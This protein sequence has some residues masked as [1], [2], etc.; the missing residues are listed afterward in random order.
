MA[1]IAD[2]IE[3]FHSGMFRGH[4]FGYTIVCKIIQAGY[5][6]PTMFNEAFAKA[7]NCEKCQRFIGRKRNAALPLESI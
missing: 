3:E 4:F 1:K 7:Q 2:L 5:Y 6:Y